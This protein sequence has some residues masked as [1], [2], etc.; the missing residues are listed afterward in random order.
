VFEDLCDIEVEDGI[1]FESASI[2]AE[3]IRKDANYSG[4]RVTVLG[5][6]DGAK[7]TTQIDV[8]YGDAVRH[9][10]WWNAIYKKWLSHIAQIPYS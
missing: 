4:T 1:G 6:I 10:P 3:E 9:L 7:C 5:S 8:G 2:T